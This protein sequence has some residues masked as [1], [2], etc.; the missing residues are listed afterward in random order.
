ML[1]DQIVEAVLAAL[2]FVRACM[3]WLLASLSG[4]VQAHP[5]FIEVLVVLAL[6]TMILLGYLGIQRKNRRDFNIYRGRHMTKEE[7]ELAI[8][9]MVAD[10][11]SESIDN[12]VLEGRLT[13]WEASKYFKRLGHVYGLALR[14]LQA[15]KL[16]LSPEQRE[17]L[18]EMLAVKFKSEKINTKPNIPGPRP[19]EEVPTKKTTEKAGGWAGRFR[20][21]LKTA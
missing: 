8:A 19:G 2:A 4:L 5:V 11:V 13:S 21:R 10:K 7:R 6:L 17:H 1:T 18:R 16:R 15:P 12:L 14:D 20:N 3:D 9:V